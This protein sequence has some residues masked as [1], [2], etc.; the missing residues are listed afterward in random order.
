MSDVDTAEDAEPELCEA[1]HMPHEVSPAAFVRAQQYANL[2]LTPQGA[3]ELVQDLE[4]KGEIHHFPVYDLARAA[5]LTWPTG[6]AR[7]PA[8]GFPEPVLALR[9]A[10]QNGFRLMILDGYTSLLGQPPERLV[11]V[12]IL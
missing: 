12:W 5:Q 4:R 8:V 10:P 2:I 1:C 11:P 7:L 3:K 9:G 6:G